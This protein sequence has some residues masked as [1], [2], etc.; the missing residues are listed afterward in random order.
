MPTPTAEMSVNH[1]CR[2]SIGN[3]THIAQLPNTH[4]PIFFVIFVPAPLTRL[5]KRKLIDSKVTT[6]A[7]FHS[8][9]SSVQGRRFQNFDEF[10]SINIVEIPDSKATCRIGASPTSL[11]LL[12]T[13]AVL[14][15]PLLGL[16]SL[17]VANQHTYNNWE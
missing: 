10:Q 6:M 11:E 16:R 17:Y 13:N 12:M 3:E 15:L 4:N 7:C 5:G 1:L 14:N 9:S 8:T 2:S